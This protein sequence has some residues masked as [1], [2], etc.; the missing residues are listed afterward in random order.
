MVYQQ[1]TDR[2]GVFG[3]GVNV[4]VIRTPGDGAVL[5]DTG[6]NE[7]NARKLLRS[8]RDEQ[9]LE[10]RAILTTH[11]HADHFGGHE[12]VVKRTAAQVYAPLIE[13]TI[14]QFPK[15]QPSLLF[16]GAAPPAALRE[17]FILARPSPV[18]EVIQGDHV[19]IEDIQV[20]VAPLPGHSPNQVGYVVDGVF[21]CADVVFP[22]S[23]IEKYRIP[24][25]YDLD[26]HVASMDSAL[27]IKCSFV[28]PGHGPV[29]HDIRRLRD[30]NVA[31]VEETTTEI[32]AHLDEPL[33]LDILAEAVF[34][35]MRVPILGHVSY[36]LLRP[37]IAAYLSSLEAAGQVEHVI[38]GKQSRW[39]RV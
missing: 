27:S 31:I 10:A 38:E 15:L 8:V 12:F 28:V 11:A 35:S 16:G 19:E 36:Y 33:A 23:A 21:F 26:K 1:L 18:D 20:Q 25:L 37:T 9:G 39:R 6:A 22:V 32:L 4:G 3:G 29:E 34:T 24:Y 5:I 14:L 7:G 13:A 30:S 17:R 2:V